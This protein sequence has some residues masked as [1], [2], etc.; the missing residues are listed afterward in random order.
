TTASPHAVAQT[1]VFERPGQMALLNDRIFM[2]CQGPK[3]GTG[4]L[5]V[6]TAKSL[7]RFSTPVDCSGGGV[8]VVRAAAS[9]VIWLTDTPTLLELDLTNYAVRQRVRVPL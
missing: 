1:L 5:N 7:E 8:A 9:V 4:N 6:I 2:L 3:P